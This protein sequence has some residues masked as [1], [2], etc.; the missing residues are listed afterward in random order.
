MIFTVKLIFDQNNLNENFLD[1]YSGGNDL[2]V[3]KKFDQ[4]NF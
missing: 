2:A 3:I 1:K 4:I